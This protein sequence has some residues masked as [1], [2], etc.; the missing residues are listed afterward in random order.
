[1]SPSQKLRILLVAGA[2][3]W[4]VIMIGL[5]LAFSEPTPVHQVTSSCQQ[6]PEGAIPCRKEW[7][8]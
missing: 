4:V 7:S 3:P 5:Y 2:A 1:M 8:L 6:A